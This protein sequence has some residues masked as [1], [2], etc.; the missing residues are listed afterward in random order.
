MTPRLLAVCF[1]VLLNAC[2]KTQL[3]CDLPP[4]ETRVV[5]ALRDSKLRLMWASAHRGD[6]NSGP[7][8]SIESIVAA[9]RYG[10]PL[11]EIDI[12]FSR[13]GTPFL[14]HD[15][16]VRATNSDSPGE[17]HGKPAAGLSDE[18][19]A[20]MRQPGTG[21]PVLFFA[22]AIER[23]KPFKSVLELD[24]KGETAKGLDALISTARSA[25]FTD[26]V[27]FQ[28]QKFESLVYLR[29]HYPEALV[30]ARVRSAEAIDKVLPYRPEFVFAEE[31]IMTPEAIEKVH[32]AG[33]KAGIQILG[34]ETDTVENWERLFATG[35][36][37][38]MTDHGNK[39]MWHIRNKFCR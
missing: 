21:S 31:A 19:V 24:I 30:L 11:I 6:R 18:Q 15:R 27:L 3:L 7:D 23:T 25:E 35:A 10:V 4:G 32:D 17:L 14:F 36:D 33:L 38:L 37:M 29:E 13:E 1:L 16:T 5:D 28:C 34:R 2:A 12:R 39:M 26:R 8:N 9:A 20:A 22:E